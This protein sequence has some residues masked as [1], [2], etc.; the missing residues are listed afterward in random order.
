MKS[1]KRLKHCS[2]MWIK[3]TEMDYDGLEIQ[4]DNGGVIF[5]TKQETKSGFPLCIMLFFQH[6]IPI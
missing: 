3:E 2:F 4:A 5:L 1:I 6:H